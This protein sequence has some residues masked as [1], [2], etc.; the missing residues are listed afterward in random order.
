MPAINAEQLSYILSNT[1]ASENVQHHPSPI[2]TSPTVASKMATSTVSDILSSP[3]TFSVDVTEGEDMDDYDLVTPV[4]SR[5]NSLQLVDDEHMEIGNA[6][7][8]ASL[9]SNNV[10]PLPHLAK[11]TPMPYAATRL[12]DQSTH[13]A[14][15]TYFKPSSYTSSNAD[16]LSLWS[17][18]AKPYDATLDGPVL[19]KVFKTSTS[20]VASSAPVPCTTNPPP[21]GSGAM[22]NGPVLSKV[23]NTSSSAQPSTNFVSTSTNVGKAKSAGWSGVAPPASTHSKASFKVNTHSPC[24]PIANIKLAYVKKLDCSCWYCGGGDLKEAEAE[25]TIVT[26]ASHT[27]RGVPISCDEAQEDFVSSQT[28]SSAFDMMHTSSYEEV[29]D[30]YESAGCGA[31][32]VRVGAHPTCY[33]EV[34]DAYVSS[35][36]GPSGGYV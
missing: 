2:S 12:A 1:T 23:F 11:V 24:L 21:V 26:S 18:T 32:A 36:G 20:G 6:G 7:I 27:M 34:Q 25:P 28:P 30:A 15:S 14:S 5:R 10:G 9:P 35:F 19:S 4:T 8:G 16:P 3:S 22:P 17:I 13:E 31:T 33:E 29:Q